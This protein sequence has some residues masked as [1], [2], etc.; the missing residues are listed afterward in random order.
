M[1]IFAIPLR[2]KATSNNWDSCVRQLNQTIKSIFNQTCDDFKCIIACNEMPELNCEYDSRLEF[3]PLDLPIPETWLEMSRD[4][5]WKLTVIAVRIRELLETQ[6]YPENGIYVMPVDADDLL[7]RRI[8]EHC[9]NFPDENGFVSKDGYVWKLGEKF[10]RKYPQMHTY[11][12]SCN[13]IKMYRDDLPENYP[14]P[15]ELCHDQKTA[16]VLNAR[17][18]IRFDHNMVVERYAN[19]GKSFSILPFRSTVYVLGTGDNISAIFHAGEKVENQKRFHP[20]AFLRSINIF[21]MQR[22]S[23]RIKREFGM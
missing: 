16:A 2:A 6:P 14:V 11:C 18:P 8:A 5:L 15:M 21:S 9:K 23:N 17:Y 12:G 13:I 3:I 22:I 19:E 20:V 4:K 10:F 7:N 1:V